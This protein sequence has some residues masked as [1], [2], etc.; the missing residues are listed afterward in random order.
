MFSYTW[1]LIYFYYRGGMKNQLSP[2]L[3]FLLK[4][5]DGASRPGGRGKLED[6]RAELPSPKA[7]ITNGI[8][9]SEIQLI[10]LL[11]VTVIVD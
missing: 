5:P 6:G 3:V 2:C 7:A 1:F 9:T 10:Q 11:P 8:P 4:C